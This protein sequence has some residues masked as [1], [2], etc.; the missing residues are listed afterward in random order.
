ML[1]TAAQSAICSDTRCT[2]V[3]QHAPTAHS[4]GPYAPMQALTT[5]KQ[6]P[7]AKPAMY[8][9]YGHTHDSTERSASLRLGPPSFLSLL[10]TANVICRHAAVHLMCVTIVASRSSHCVSK[11]VEDVSCGSTGVLTQ[12]YRYP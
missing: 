2:D 12:S 5:K 1:V 3:P 6:M 4:H 11:H 8:S 7:A 9:R 10:V